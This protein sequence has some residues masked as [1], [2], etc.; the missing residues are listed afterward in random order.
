MLVSGRT[1]CS[2]CLSFLSSS[3]LTRSRSL[4][5]E[6]IHIPSNTPSCAFLAT[7][8]AHRSSWARDRTQATAVTQAAAVATG[9]LTPPSLRGVPRLNH[10]QAYSSV[11]LYPFTLL[12][13]ISTFCLHLSPR[14]KLSLCPLTLTPPRPESPLLR[15]LS[16]WFCPW[17][18][19]MRCLSF[20]VCL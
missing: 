7:P 17:T 18:R 5:C 10:L 9:S 11:A 16:R 4:S 2:A 15:V 19:L 13:T 14:P 3:L 8:K 6:K 20:C 1:G 12:G